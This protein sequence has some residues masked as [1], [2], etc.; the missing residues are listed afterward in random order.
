VVAYGVNVYNGQLVNCQTGIN[1]QY[2]TVNARNMLFAKVQSGF[3]IYYTGVYAQNTTFSSNSNLVVYSNAGAVTLNN[4]ILANVSQLISGYPYNAIAGD[5]N[6]FYNSPVFGTGQVTNN[7]YPFQTVGGGSYYLTNGCNFFNQGTTNI[8]PVLLAELPTKTT[9]PPIY[10]N[11][12][13]SSATVLSP[14]VQR[15]NVGNPDLGYH[16]D[17]LD[18]LLT[19]VTLSASLTLTNGVAVGLLGGYLASIYPQTGANIFS[20]GL[21]QLMNR[22]VSCQNVQEQP[23]STAGYGFVFL[24]GVGSGSPSY[25]FRFTDFSIGQGGLGNLFVNDAMVPFNTISFQDCWLRETSLSGNLIPF[26][27]TNETIGLTNNLILRG[28]INLTFYGDYYSFPNVAVFNGYNNSFQGGALSLTLYAGS[29][30]IPDG[31]NVKD[32]LFD[33]CSPSFNIGDLGAL[34]QFHASNNGFTTGTTNSW[35][36]SAYNQTNFLANYQ[37]G[38]LGNCYLPTN[39][40]LINAGSRTANLA[41]LY[42]YTTQT[43]QVKETNS[44]VDIGYHYVAVDAYGNPLDTN[45]DGIP[46]YL[47]DANGNGVVDGGELIWDNRDVDGDGLPDWWEWKYFGHT[48]IDANADPDGDGLTNLQEY[49]AGTN[50]NVDDSTV[51]GSRLNYLYDAGGWLQTVSGAHSGSVSPDSEGNIQNV[52]Q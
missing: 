19:N 33:G 23:L 27:G 48:G 52:S 37:T 8:D 10:C 50:P 30:T 18:Y 16:Y 21:P 31:W 15:D 38:P 40:I 3:N 25:Q 51:T 1:C 2:G 9:Y 41:G 5:H 14:V 24:N 28:S 47:E 45:G 49:Q 34:Y 35:G 26:S 39:S 11:T 13:I 4:C 7:F 44:I 43:N 20:T 6:G 32:N 42:H 29:L 22:I 12:N 17:P 46:D 36:Y